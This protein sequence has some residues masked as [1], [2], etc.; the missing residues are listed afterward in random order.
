[1]SEIVVLKHIPFELPTEP[2]KTRRQSAQR[3]K[4]TDNANPAKKRKTGKDNEIQGALAL[5]ELARN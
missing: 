2:V 4:S 3:E 5:I 1:M